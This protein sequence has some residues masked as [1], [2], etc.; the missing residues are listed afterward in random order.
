[1]DSPES[2]DIIPAPMAP[3][4]WAGSSLGAWRVSPSSAPAPAANAPRA[5]V[6]AATVV[7]I[8]V[9]VRISDLQ[10]ICLRSLS[11]FAVQTV[12]RSRGGGMERGPGPLPTGWAPWMVNS[13]HAGARR[14]EPGC[15]MAH[16][17][18]IVEDELKRSEEHTSELQSLMRISYAVFCLKKKTQRQK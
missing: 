8:L 12:C 16:T 3:P 7:R 13:D 18:L 17:I 9:L 11:A 1:M 5:S 4:I 6:P 2:P 14:P 15:A 10:S